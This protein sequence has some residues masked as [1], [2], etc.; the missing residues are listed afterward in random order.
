MGCLWRRGAA[1]GGAG[2]VA[3][4]DRRPRCRRRCGTS[5]PVTRAALSHPLPPP[6][7]EQRR[8][9]SMVRVVDVIHP[10]RRLHG[11]GRR[12]PLGLGDVHAGE[13][14]LRNLLRRDVVHRLDAR[15]ARRVLDHDRVGLGR[16][17]QR[18]ELLAGLVDAVLRVARRH[19]LRVLAEVEER[20]RDVVV[21][22]VEAPLAVRLDLELD[23]RDLHRAEL[24]LEE[25]GVEELLAVRDLHCVPRRLPLV[26]GWKRIDPE[27]PAT[28]YVAV[29][30][31]LHVWKQVKEV[32]PG[33]V[34]CIL[35]LID[36][37][38]A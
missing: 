16:V 10:T 27:L 21:E 32:T 22:R 18:A 36:I 31:F 5:A 7:A 3:N 17:E 25:G 8:R 28:C 15:N 1:E 20:R 19:H 2:V 11:D 35:E 26:D 30:L 23:V 34:N 38:V 12:R 9:R 6:W 14:L 33:T 4:P 29:W 13:L 24:R 37:F